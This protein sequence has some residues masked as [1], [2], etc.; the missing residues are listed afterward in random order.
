MLAPKFSCG[1]E[2]APTDDV[3]NLTLDQI[4]SGTGEIINRQTVAYSDAGSSSFVFDEDTLLY[5]KLRPYLN[6]VVWPQ[7]RGVATTELVPLKPDRDLILPGYLLHY[8]RS[9]TFLNYIV[10]RVAGAKMPR[11]VMDDFWAHEVPH[12]RDINEQARI[13]ELLDQADAL[14]RQR[15]EADAKLARLLPALFRHHFGDPTDSNS[16]VSTKPLGSLLKSIDSGDSPRCL[17]RQAGPDEWS[18]LKLGAVTW[19]RFDDSQNKA[20]PDDM[21]PD[22]SLEVSTGDLLFARKNTLE[23]VGATALVR[24]TRPKLLLPDLIFRLVPREDAKITKEYLWC[25]LSHPSMRNRLR[26]IASGAA[27]SMPNIS[28]SRLETIEIPLPP[29]TTQL[30]FSRQVHAA[31]DLETQ[32]AASAAKLET[33]FQTLLHR[34]F[35][36]ELTARWREA[37][38][39]EGVQQEM[40]RHART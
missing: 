7:E 4:T 30:V 6:K 16:A 40:T 25:L 35:T 29:H 24:E 9:P 34:A 20:L 14:R 12:P 2:F 11:V 39:R 19:G 22:A 32:A 31:L 13:V 15:A 38:L 36:G 10:G 5:S 3:W 8:L 1:V 33:L 21:Q 28:K 27:G 26:S 17:D 37:H 18:V 23:L